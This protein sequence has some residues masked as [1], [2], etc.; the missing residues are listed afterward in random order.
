MQNG[1]GK[2]RKMEALKNEY[3]K[4]AVQ[5]AGAKF[6]LSITS[7][8]PENILEVACGEEEEFYFHSVKAV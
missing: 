6:I 1:A 5:S 2:T 4:Q 8:G 7:K 3:T